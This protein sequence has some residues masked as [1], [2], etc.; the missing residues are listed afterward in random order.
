M[1]SPQNNSAQNI[2]ATIYFVAVHIP[3][4]LAKRGG[5][6]DFRASPRAPGLSAGGWQA[7]LNRRVHL[8]RRRLTE[9][10]IRVKLQQSRVVPNCSASRAE[11]SSLP[12]C[13]AVQS[14]VKLLRLDCA[15]GGGRMEV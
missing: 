4:F 5:R 3:P 12:N 14:R 11:Q 7:R 13:E 6:G 8:Q 15:A 9:P 10:G 1:K 2:D